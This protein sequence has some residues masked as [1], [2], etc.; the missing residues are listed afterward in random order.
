MNIR[1]FSGILFGFLALSAG[2]AAAQSGWEGSYL[3]V[4]LGYGDM[5]SVHCDGGCTSSIGPTVSGQGAL[6]G[7]AYGHDWQNGPLVYGVEISVSAAGVDGGSGSV[8][9]Y[10]CTSTGC[11]TDIQSVVML[12]GRVGRD[13]GSFLPYVTAGVAA[14]QV[15]GTLTDSGSDTLTSPVLGIGI[16]AKL[17]RPWTA[18]FEINH[19]F[20]TDGFVFRPGGCLSPG[21]AVEDISLTTLQL[22]LNYRF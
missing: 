6:L 18:T 21:C 9:S 3:G 16:E 8:P 7:I 14:M 5:S 12:R 11:L 10:G 19:V 1:T 2:P 4:T 13:L 20:E 17:R 15:E 22:G